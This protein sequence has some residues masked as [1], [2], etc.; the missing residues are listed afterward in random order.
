[1]VSERIPAILFQWLRNANRLS[2]G[3]QS[4]KLLLDDVV[5][6]S[7]D[8]DTKLAILREYLESVKPRNLPVQDDDEADEEKGV[9]LSDIMEMWSFA[10]QTNNDGVMSSVA[11]V[12][13]LLLQ[14]VSASLELVPYGLG[15]CKTL[16]QERQLKSL[17]KNLSV[18][19]GKGFVLSPTLRML[20]EAVCLDGGAFAKRIFRARHS[21]FASLGRNLEIGLGENVVEEAR[22]TSVRTNAVRF[23]LSCLKYLHSD[24][25]REL[26]SQ[27][28]LM[29]HL[30]FMLRG[31]PAYLVIEILDHLK[32]YALMDDKLPRDVK[33]RNFNTKTLLRILALYTYSVPSPEETSSVV[34][35][36]H[37]F[38]LYICTSPSA[39]ILYPSTGFYPKDSEEAQ[40]HKNTGKGKEKYQDSVPVYNFVLSE[41]APKLKPWSNLKHSALLIAIFKAAPELIADYFHNTRTFTFEPK[42][43]MTWI[44]YAAFLFNT[45]ASP[46]PPNFGD[47]SRYNKSPPPI[48]ILLDNII[49]RPINQK[50]LQRCLASKSHLISFFATRIL[51]SA[52]ERL[53]KAVQML[54]SHPQTRE[55]TQWVEAS[56]QLIDG[57]CQRVPDM[58][59][60]VQSYKGIPAENAL[61]K[62]MASRLLRLYYEVIPQVA[63]AANFDVSPFFV[64]I[65]QEQGQQGQ[66]SNDAFVVLELENLVSIASFS[67]GMR[68]FA[69]VEKLSQGVDS[70]P[71]T[72]LLRLLC[73]SSS[74][75]P[76]QKLYRV[77]RDVAIENQL[78][79]ERI[80]LMPLIRT[81]RSLDGSIDSDRWPVIWSYLDNCINRCGTS[82]LKYLEQA[83]ETTGSQPVQADQPAPSLLSFTLLEQL[84]FATSGAG[85]REKKALAKFFSLYMNALKASGED[86]SVLEPLHERVRGHFEDAKEISKLGSKSELKILQEIGDISVES[87]S[88]QVTEQP[89]TLQVDQTALKEML[90]VPVNQDPDGSALTKW[91]TKSVEDLIDDD[92]ITRLVNL[93]VSPHPHIRKEAHTA[94]LH[95][96]AKIKASSHED[97]DQIW[98]LLSEFTESTRSLIDSPSLRAQDDVSPVPSAFVAF[99]TH[100]LPILLS[101]LH[102]LYPKLNSYLTSS[103]HWPVQKLPL[104]HSIL[105]SA[106]SSEDKY[107]TELSFLLSYLLDSLT[108]PQ[109]LATFHQKRWFEKIFALM[110]NSFLRQNLKSKVF[111]LVYRCTEIQGGCDVLITRFGALSWLDGLR[112]GS[113]MEEAALVEALMVRIWENC[114]K[115]KAEKWSHGGVTK[116]MSKRMHGEEDRSGYIDVEMAL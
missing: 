91:S 24:G 72:A 18:E 79:P 60:A 38:L 55:N 56:R 85:K 21:T 63:L 31:D 44:G 43:S 41:F 109:D 80:G 77:L 99:T 32:K 53:G 37:E 82:P 67:P 65:L 30:T 16:L 70:S 110:S 26:L 93:L 74:S 1:M 59:E 95:L 92:W 14:A 20:K 27:K 52:M 76:P 66:D 116:L 83:S 17:A 71:Y 13:A 34:D 104:V 39:G 7:E 36:T 84:P 8:R 108:T 113:D 89:E 33:F 11:V 50:V 107:Y 101:P 94:L 88:S 86:Q 78:V 58:K 112:G 106:P 96:T 49:P 69:K 22:K 45:M 51:V 64:N 46:I 102:P 87:D 62:T 73:Y 68:W 105:H 5:F 111:R 90:H 61:Q 2:L 115:Q 47:R 29:S 4:L 100:S 114:D 42:L 48:P 75:A 9:F 57:F 3:L 25:R 98:L 12:L 54:N 6:E 10:S 81:L 19:K 103:P 15:I 23:F 35:A 28:D 97:K 40:F